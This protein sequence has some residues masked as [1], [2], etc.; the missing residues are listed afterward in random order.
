MEQS[1]LLR[2]VAI[3]LESLGIPYMLVGSFGSGIHGEPRQT[4]ASTS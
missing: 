3:R 4:N 1:E 2:Y